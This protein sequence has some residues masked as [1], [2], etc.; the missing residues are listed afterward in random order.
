MYLL[1]PIMISWTASLVIKI[2]LEDKFNSTVDPEEN[3]SA[4]GLPSVL[5]GGSAYPIA[6]CAINYSSFYQLYSLAT[7]ATIC[8]AILIP[9]IPL[10]IM[11]TPLPA[12]IEPINTQLAPGLLCP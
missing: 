4:R 3:M 2:H 11:T 5:N 9:Y 8:I 6:R 7:D 12:D 10:V 1:S